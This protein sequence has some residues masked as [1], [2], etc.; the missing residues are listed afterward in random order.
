VVNSPHSGFDYKAGPANMHEAGE[1]ARQFQM[2]LRIEFLRASTFI[3][4]L[5]TPLKM[6]ERA[7]MRLAWGMFREGT[8]QVEKRLS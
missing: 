5:P 8:E 2:S 4:T 3:A 1:V 6:R 7:D